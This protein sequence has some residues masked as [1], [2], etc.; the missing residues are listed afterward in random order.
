ME[1]IKTGDRD[2]WFDNIKGILIF[3][4]VFGHIIQKYIHTRNSYIYMI[5]VIIYCFHMP[6]FIFLSGYFSKDAKKAQDRAFER[7]LLPYIVWEFVWFAINKLSGWNSDF[8]FAVPWFA[9]WYFLTLFTLSLFLPILARIRFVVPLLFVLALVSGLYVDYGGPFSLGRTICFSGFFMLGYYCDRTVLEKIRK[10]RI[11][12][13]IMAALVVA[14][15][16]YLCLSTYARSRL[17]KIERSLWLAEAYRST[18]IA[19][20]EGSII[21]SIIMVSAFFLGGFIIAFTPRKKTYL[22]VIGKN[23]LTVF[24]IHGFIVDLF[25]RYVDLN[26]GSVPGAVLAFVISLGITLLLSLEP[27]YKVYCRFMA[28]LLKIVTKG[29]RGKRYIPNTP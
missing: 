8:S 24:V 13:L 2:A 20:A 14:A 16:I 7:F 5:F 19:P 22:S 29:G 12:V 23:S 17:G 6:L 9:F 27:L 4:V 26:A 21:R 15:L 25:N 1:P 18:P 28:L 10:H 11:P 3:L